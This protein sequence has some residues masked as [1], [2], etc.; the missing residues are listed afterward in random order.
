M[1]LNPL[2]LLLFCVLS[3][4]SVPGLEAANYYVR[5]GA[6]GRNDGSDWNHA[7]T[8]MPE[9]LERGA[10][11]YIADGVYSSYTFN[12]AEL[13]G[14]YITV[15]K[16]SVREHG[17]DV[18]WDPVYGDGTAEFSPL[19]ITTGYW[20]IDGSYRASKDS[21]HGFRISISGE[22]GGRVQ[23]HGITVA[24]GSNKINNIAVKY[25][26]F[27]G[28][29]YGYPE[30]WI[31]NRGWE[32]WAV[33]NGYEQ[34][35]GGT[36]IY[37]GFCYFYHLIGPMQRTRN[38]GEVV[39][40]HNFYSDNKSYQG[41]PHGDAVQLWGANNGVDYAHNIVIRNNE[42]HE[43]GG[44]AVLNLAWGVND[45][46]FYGNLIYFEDNTTLKSFGAGYVYA[47]DGDV[48]A[49]YVYNNTA[50]NGPSKVGLQTGSGYVLIN[51]EQ[52]AYNNVWLNCTA[53]NAVGIN[54]EHEGYNYIVNSLLM[55]NFEPHQSNTIT[56]IDPFVDANAYNFTPIKEL[57]GKNLSQESW[58]DPQY[59]SAVDPS[60]NIRGADGAWDIGA[61]EYVSGGNQ[62]PV[63]NPIGP[64]STPVGEQIR[65][66]INATDPDG[67]PLTYSAVGE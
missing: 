56:N 5:A 63:L 20:I 54:F 36:H 55:W 7:W 46:H 37:I 53:T 18:G 48:G 31:D 59:D 17:T 42:F 60:G 58:W 51:T 9:T 44:T 61:Y 1:T 39:I 52:Y 67:D 64:K 22:Q 21:G 19:S 8:T 30:G 12:D 29:F 2:S 16:A 28:D 24:N 26:A 27:V 62:P 41:G 49:L 43:I 11:Y 40:E 65:F 47:Y 38:V 10:T 4:A 50:Y 35:N 25:T 57:V 33:K 23:E 32:C 66:Q 45:I 6:A 3:T 14:E 15:K 13:G 34:T